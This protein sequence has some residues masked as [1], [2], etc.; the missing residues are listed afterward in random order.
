MNLPTESPSAG[1]GQE[2][3][4]QVE[5]LEISVSTDRDRNGPSGL[6]DDSKSVHRSDPEATVFTSWAWLR[7][8]LSVLT[9]PWWV[10]V[11]R[12]GPP[13]FDAAE[14][15]AAEVRHQILDSLGRSTLDFLR[16][17]ARRF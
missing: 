8:R 2:I 3:K 11:V 1:E 10:L 15:Y 13:E 5:G 14:I 4:D 7:G 6:E 17:A 16:Q 9:E 12:S